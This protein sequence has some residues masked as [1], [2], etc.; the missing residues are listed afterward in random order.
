MSCSPTGR[1]VVGMVTGRCGQPR[2]GRPSSHSP[3]LHPSIRWRVGR[4]RGPRGGR[5]SDELAKCHVARA[6]KPGAIKTF[7]FVGR[8]ETAD[9]RRRGALGA[10]EVR[11]RLLPPR[12]ARAHPSVRVAFLADCTRHRDPADELGAVRPARRWYGR[13]EPPGVR[14]LSALRTSVLFLRAFDD[15]PGT[16]VGRAARFADYL[17]DAIEE[18]TEGLK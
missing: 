3:R 5:P 4:P 2:P 18:S 10:L 7:E 12:T 16:A 1:A 14:G 17:W 15:P 8:G 13:G 6:K 11:G 9:V